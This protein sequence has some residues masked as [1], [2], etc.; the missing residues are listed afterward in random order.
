MRAFLSRYLIVLR[1]SRA[2]S[3]RDVGPMLTFGLRAPIH[4][5]S[6]CLSLGLRELDFWVLG[7]A[8]CFMSAEPENLTVSPL[9]RLFFGRNKDDLCR[10]RVIGLLR[11]R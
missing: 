6:S 5:S 9:P 2:H 1:P 4:D 10:S 7:L 11:L 3:N 8:G